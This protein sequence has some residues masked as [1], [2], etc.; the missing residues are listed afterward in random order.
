MQSSTIVMHRE[1][2]LASY[3]ILMYSSHRDEKHVYDKLNVE[4]EFL[5][6]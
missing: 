6:I 1:L 2:L 4:F 3:V 5:Y